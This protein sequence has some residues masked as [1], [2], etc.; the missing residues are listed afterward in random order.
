MIF[1]FDVT[2]LLSQIQNAIHQCPFKA[3]VSQTWQGVLQG[4]GDKKENAKVRIILFCIGKKT[5]HLF[6]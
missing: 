2:I 6:I 1:L 3:A 5:L 4:M